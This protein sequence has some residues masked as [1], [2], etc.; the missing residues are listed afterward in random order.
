MS[1]RQA[2]GPAQPS[3]QSAT[4]TF[5]A[6]IP[7]YNAERF[8]GRAIASVVA[9]KGVDVECI[10]VDDGSSDG[11]ARVA[12]SFGNRVR[13]I[14]QR[15][16]GASSARNTGLR[17]ASGEYVAFLDADDY[18]LDTKLVCQA[19]VLAQFPEAALV[20]A[21]WKWLPSRDVF[22]PPDMSG[23]DPDIPEAVLC[24]GWASILIDPYLCTPS[25][26]VRRLDALACGGFDTSLP[27]AE[28]LDFFMRVCR[29]RPYAVVRT[30]LV[31]CQL[32]AGSLTQSENSHRHN[33]RVLDGVAA[34]FPE[35]LQDHA[36]VIAKAKADIYRRWV[37]SLIFRGDGSGARE[38]LK[39][40]KVV[41]GV[42]GHRRL[43]MKS[44]LA[45]SIKGLRDVLRPQASE[46][47]VRQSS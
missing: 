31:H 15:N 35:V 40:S 18:W 9:Q 14:S 41:G 32:R 8:L 4:P 44:H 39:E 46:D 34:S 11:T 12:R 21:L 16:G 47:Q 36:G 43:W 38:V 30:P 10:V 2:T 6:V 20:S 26:V 45:A 24:P 29:G 17:A 22:K 42:V 25:V 7:A 28:D 1:F 33:L 13:L 5:S 19:R 3:H 27:S 37:R 23:P